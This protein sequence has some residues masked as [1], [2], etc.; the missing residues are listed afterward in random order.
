MRRDRLGESGFT[1]LEVVVAA[2]VLALGLMGLL[3]AIPGGLKLMQTS[4]ETQIALTCIRSKL[5]EMR[6]AD[7][8]TLYDTYNGQAVIAF[9]D[10]DL[11][12]D[13]TAGEETL[14]FVPT[15]TRHGLVTFLREAEAA[16]AWGTG[17]VDLNADGDGADAPPGGGGTGQAPFQAFAISITL[18]WQSETGTRSVKLVDLIYDG[19]S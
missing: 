6:A 1:I 16:A 17:T 11:S 19:G 14:P 3:S 18:S 7:F 10:K 15:M 12:G 13:F 2:A 9:E 5:E 8:D 4:R